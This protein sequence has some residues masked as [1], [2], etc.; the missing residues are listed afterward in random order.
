M[1]Y[2]VTEPCINCRYGECVE[3]C[4]VEAF[5]QGPNFMAIDPEVCINCSI[6][7]MVCPVAAIKSEYDLKEDER[8]FIEI[9][10]RLA[11]TWPVVKIGEGPL[12]EAATWASRNDKAHFLK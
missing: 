3:V 5:H 9:N 11:Y 4:P 12:P 10:R 6:C 7:E 8:A 2:V 1:A